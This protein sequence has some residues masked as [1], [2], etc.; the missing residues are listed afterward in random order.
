MGDRSILGP[1]DISDQAFASLLADQAG[2]GEPQ[3][4]S[5][6]AEVAD[7]DLEALTTA[8]RYWVRGTAQHGSGTSPYALFVKVVQSWTRNAAFQQV[9]EPLREIAAQSLP[10]RTEPD[11]YRSDLA[12]RLPAGLSMPRCYAVLDIDELSTA[13]WLEGVDLDRRPWRVST[14]ERAAYLLGRLAASPAVRPVTATG[15]SAVV[16]SYVQGRVEHQILPSLRSDDLW[17]HPLVSAA[18][19][20]ELR[21]RLV[22]AADALPDLVEELDR[23]PLGA[24]H[25]D[26]CPRNLLIANGA[27]DDF[28]LIDFGFW[29]EAPLGFDL[30]QL[31]LGEMQV[32]ERSAAEIVE[33]ERACLP[34]YVTGLHD[35]GSEV[36]LEVVRR[37]HALLM[38]VFWGLSAPPLEVLFGRPA[39]G[40]AAVIRERA[41]AARFV[42]DL[43][44]ETSRTAATRV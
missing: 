31:L 16:R 22:A 32:G 30:G 9:P 20:S 37:S 40:G 36:S 5:C 6:Q 8:G 7:Y 28:V 39:P 21:D 13:L 33:L 41:Q 17:R 10:W 1:A 23:A 26:A 24:A 38:L 25:G 43:A 4:I 27:L 34:A 12:A 15:S 29:C 2:A 35:E 3:V 18:F 11:V 44:E 19:D 42:L 14:F